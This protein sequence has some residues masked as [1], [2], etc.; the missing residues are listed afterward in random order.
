MG[1]S[2][3]N[4]ACVAIDYTGDNTPPDMAPYAM[5]HPNI[6]DRFTH[7]GFC[8]YCDGPGL[9]VVNCG[10]ND[11]FVPDGNGA[12]NCTCR[13]N[14]Y[15]ACCRKACKRNKYT[16]TT[17][18]CCQA[19][20]P[21]YYMDGKIVRTCDPAVRADKWSNKTCDQSMSTYCKQGD[22]LFTP[23]CRQWV[24]T[25]YPAEGTKGVVAN[26]AIDDV[27]LAVCNR[28]E[29]AGR[30]ECACIVAANEVRLKLPNSNNIPVQCM[31]NKC[32][33]NPAAYR[34]SSQMTPC[35]I[36]NCQ[37][38]TS[39]LKIIAGDPN[40]FNV[41]FSQNCGTGSAP[42]TTTNT[43]TPSTTSTTGTPSTTSTQSTSAAMT[44]FK[45]NWIYLTIGLVVLV[46]LIILIIYF[47]SGSKKNKS[48]YDMDSNYGYADS[49]GN[50]GY[51]DPYG[52][53]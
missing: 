29:N 42:S 17:D 9:S 48:N 32:A 51:S 10:T 19:G 8:E 40:T 31:M 16:G 38:D 33:N 20:G 24:T 14:C 21:A 25:F 13:F 7:P 35:N 45:K 34:T 46:I 43:G 11:E 39:D 36:T 5:S 41:G 27:I 6:G 44:F 15:P 26:G 53:Y 1:N 23:A 18:K 49:Y 2:T 12:G 3:S 37:I 4:S 22:N 28:P 50:P 52:R 30:N 47:T